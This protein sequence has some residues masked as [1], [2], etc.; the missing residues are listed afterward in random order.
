VL[1]WIISQH[2]EEAAFQW[3]LR[4]DAACAPHYTL[5]EL[6]R[7]DEVVAAHLDGLFL[8][9]DQGWDICRAELDWAEPGEL[10]A[11]SILGFSSGLTDRIEIVIEAAIAS[12]EAAPGLAS[13][14]GWMPYEE[15]RPHIED[16]LKN[17]EPILRALGFSSTAWHRQD[18]GDC[19]KSALGK[20]DSQVTLQALRTVGELGRQDLLPMCQEFVN[21]DDSETEF[22]ATWA[23]VVLGDRSAAER[24]ATIATRGGDR[25][26][27]SCS[28]A[29]RAM[30]RERAISWHLELVSDESQ[31]RLAIIAA[32]ACGGPQQIPWL[33]E[34]MSD[35]EHAR[36][37]GE[38]FAFIV[39]V[40]LSYAEL[41][42]DRPEGFESG[43][44]EDSD[45]DDV[46]LDLDEDLLWPAPDL[47]RSWW[48]KNE[49]RFDLNRRY[50]VGGLCE[51]T[52]LIEVL[53]NGW[54][55]QR[56]AAALELVLMDPGQPLFEVRARGDRQINQLHKDW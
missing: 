2:A 27:M 29:A 35:D 16:L 31:K 47:V 3:L 56:A 45:D 19:L 30:D 22:W 51:R 39:G 26:E 10:Y 55:R 24:L 18:P 9:G 13:A 32:G 11:A 4:G 23:A 53:R 25:A 52:S 28:V 15:V 36:I 21:S 37:A 17:D 5:G 14:L 50:L 44:N 33:I 49:G 40:D 12:P 46:D 6:A 20:F 41:E 8:A 54:Q 7:L 42:R 48:E 38:S 43:P 34:A 1:P